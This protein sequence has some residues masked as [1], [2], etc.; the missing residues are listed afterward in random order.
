MRIFIAILL[1]ISLSGCGDIYRYF[2]SGE[3]GWNLKKELRDK[4]VSKV[5]LAKLTDFKWD[6]FVIFNPY[7]PTSEICKHLKLLSEECKSAITVES[8]D[9]GEML[10]VFRLKGKVVH[11][12][13]H[14][15]WHGDFTPVSEVSFTP[16]TAVFSVSIEGK[17]ALGED[18]LKLRSFHQH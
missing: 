11:T 5:E 10:M 6:E 3:V 18:W 15:R 16:Q 14:I 9:D 4:K 7:Q 8:T 1:V 2:N 17:G 13:K 12:E